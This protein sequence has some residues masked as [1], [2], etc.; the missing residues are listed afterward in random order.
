MAGSGGNPGLVNQNL[1]EATNKGELQ[2]NGTTIN[3]SGGTITATGANATVTL[4]GSTIVQ[5]GTLNA[6]SGGTMQTSGEV[7][8]DGTTQGAM[9]INGTYL[10]NAASSETLTT[11]TFN[12]NGNFQIN[13]GNGQNAFILLNGNTTL[14][15]SGAGTVTLTTLTGGGSAYLYENGGPFTLTTTNNTIQ[16]E[17]IVGAGTALTVL[18]QAAGTINANSTGGTLNNTLQIQLAGSGGNPGLV[19]QNLMEATN[20]GTLEPSLNHH[21]QRRRNHFGRWPDRDCAT[22]WQHCRP[23]RHAERPQWRNGADLRPGIHWMWK[24]SSGAITINGSYLT[25]NAST[26]Y[27]PRDL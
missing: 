16:G 9:T 10:T 12:N 8:L 4:T 14:Q 25:G 3:N 24:H 7:F 6:L 26:T 21:Q 13:G 1:L 5:G 15:G 27:R 18:N 11:G 20:S 2:I 17:G 23:G 19:N 22:G